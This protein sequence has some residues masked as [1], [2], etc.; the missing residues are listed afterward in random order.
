MWE[1]C[2]FGLDRSCLIAY[3]VSAHHRFEVC[4]WSDN[5]GMIHSADEPVQGR[6]NASTYLHNVLKCVPAYTWLFDVLS[7]SQNASKP[8]PTYL[9]S[10]QPMQP[11]S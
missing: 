4:S 11:V 2:C 5:V 7:P 8:L 9:T 10:A 1:V 3:C 6:V